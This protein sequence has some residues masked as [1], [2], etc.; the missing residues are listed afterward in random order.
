M[1]FHSE[2]NQIDCL[3]ELELQSEELKKVYTVD[4]SL[5][6]L[7]IINVSARS[8]REFM[9]RSRNENRFPSSDGRLHQSLD[10]L[11]TVFRLLSTEWPPPSAFRLTTK[12]Q[13]AV[14]AFG[15]RLVRRQTAQPLTRR[16]KATRRR[17]HVRSPTTRRRDE[18]NERRTQR[19]PHGER[20]TTA[21]RRRAK[22]P[23]SDA[24][25]VACDEQPVVVVQTHA[26]G[27]GVKK[28]R[29]EMRRFAG[30]ADRLRIGRSDGRMQRRSSD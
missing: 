13:R 14:A 29:D 26:F 16:T 20:D 28:T 19:G 23:R 27:S 22:T 24:R 4:Y 2:T 8:V 17:P 1:A 18:K 21:S 9:L 3:C 11:P 25:T 15:R 30:I 6:A 5:H 12:T 10:S 7:F